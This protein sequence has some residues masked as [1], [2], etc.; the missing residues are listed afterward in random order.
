MNLKKLLFDRAK[1]LQRY[2]HNLKSAKPENLDCERILGDLTKV[3]DFGYF[4][5]SQAPDIQMITVLKLMEYESSTQFT[6]KEVEAFK[7]GLAA[8][9]S[10]LEAC[11]QESEQRRKNLL[12]K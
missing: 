8:I 1:N 10:F 4:W 6:K 9:P 2:F 7:L 12:Q 3:G 5:K 11:F